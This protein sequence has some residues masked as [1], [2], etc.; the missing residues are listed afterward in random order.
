MEFDPV[1]ERND[2]IEM[3]R[4]TTEHSCIDELNDIL[5]RNLAGLS[6][7]EQQV[8][9]ERFAIGSCAL[10][11]KPKPKTLRQVGALIGVTKE[12]VRQIQNKAMKKLRCALEVHYLAA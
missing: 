2:G 8:I 1:N 10:D 11:S 9:T 3:Q 6:S 7:I 4:V 5:T 12:R